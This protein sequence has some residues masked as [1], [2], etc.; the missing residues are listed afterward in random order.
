MANITISSTMDKGAA[1]RLL[2]SLQNQL[3]NWDKMKAQQKAD[4]EHR[5]AELKKAIGK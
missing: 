3:A 5:I 1:E 2:A 4:L